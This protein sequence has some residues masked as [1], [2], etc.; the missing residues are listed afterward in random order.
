MQGKRIG[1]GRTAEVWEHGAG[2][3]LK[4]YR[5][6]IPAHDAEREYEISKYAFGQNLQTPRPFELVADQ[7]RKGIVFQQV[8][9]RSMLGLIG[10]KPWKLGEYAGQ[11]AALHYDLHKL[12]GPDASG[13][14]KESLKSSIIAAPMLLMEEKTAILAK[15]EP[16]PAGDRLLHGD[17]HPDNVLMDG[18]A[19]IIDWMNGTAGNPVGDAARTVVLLSMGTLPPGASLSTRF[20]TGFIRQ[21]LTKGYIREYLRL[22]GLAYSEVNAWVLPVAAARLTEGIPLAEKEQLVREI[23]RRLRPES[24]RSGH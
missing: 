9:G 6:D 8:F 24:F 21:R 20:V 10:K 18:Q 14:Q 23:R 17:F 22:S 11:L 15:L 13:R 2:K 7:E 3:I 12:Q 19:W 5:E 1:E 16:L 4:L